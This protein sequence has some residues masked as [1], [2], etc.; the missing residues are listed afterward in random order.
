MKYNVELTE[1]QGPLDLLLD[2]IKK[3]NLN[4]YDIN[5]SLLTEQYLAY[6]KQLEAINLNVSSEYLV[7]ASELISIKSRKLLPN[8][9]QEEEEEFISRV[10]E[11]KLY[12]EICEHFRELETKRSRQFSKPASNLEQFKS[13]SKSEEQISEDELIDAF[14]RFFERQQ[15]IKPLTAQVT[16]KEYSITKR[17]NEILTLLED[18][19]KISFFELFTE[20]N[21]PFIIITFLTVLEMSKQSLIELV[22]KNQHQQIYLIK[23]EEV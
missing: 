11:Y 5:L 15:N 4:I 6:L 19:Q 21:K 12:K 17:T 9:E 7:I 2:L 23:K 8:Y 10:L 18:K 22:Q 20:N 3:N 16:K 1:F 14:Y 13:E